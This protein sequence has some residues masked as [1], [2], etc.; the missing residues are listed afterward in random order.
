MTATIAALASLGVAA[1]RRQYP[2]TLIVLAVALLLCAAGALARGNWAASETLHRKSQLV[3]RHGAEILT[4][5]GMGATTPAEKLKELSRLSALILDGTSGL[6]SSFPSASIAGES[7][8]PQVTAAVGQSIE[9]SLRQVLRRPVVTNVMGSV[10]VNL[11][12]ASA[13]GAELDV[14]VA[15]GPKAWQQAPSPGGRRFQ[16]TG[17]E[18]GATAQFEVAVDAP[19]LD[20]SPPRQEAQV[21]TVDAAKQW[22]FSLRGTWADDMDIWVTLYSSGRYV[23]AIELIPAPQGSRYEP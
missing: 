22:T 7:L 4:A 2:G 17:G 3:A 20:V 21:E 23:Q 6:P 9:T 11:S 1:E 15:T 19:G 12:Q 14:T 16:L 8:L 13:E 10:D 5:Y 18:D